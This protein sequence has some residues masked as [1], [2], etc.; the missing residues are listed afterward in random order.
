VAGERR[1]IQSVALDLVT[2]CLVLEEGLEPRHAPTVHQRL[3]GGPSFEWLAPPEPRGRITVADVL[4]S[5]EPAEH[6][7]VVRAW[8]RDVW[9]TWQAH[10]STIRRW[11][12]A[13]FP[14]G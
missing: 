12:E 8:A 1:T 5:R 9:E 7:R 11:A 14:A 2:L 3:A 13:A 4:L 10:H 6:E